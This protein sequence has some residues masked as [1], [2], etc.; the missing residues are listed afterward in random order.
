[1]AP[2]PAAAAPDL[3]SEDVCA[4]ELPEER[5]L[6]LARDL[7]ARGEWRLAVRALYLAALAHLG[8]R[9]LVRLARHKSNREYERELERRGAGLGAVVAGFRDAVA[10]YEPV[11]YGTH[12]ASR[13][14]YE[15]VRAGVDRVRAD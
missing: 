4:A 7:V 12:P 15:R 13:G 6:D 10:G 3:A 9:E 11:W 5:W 14:L 8:S 2:A 1:L